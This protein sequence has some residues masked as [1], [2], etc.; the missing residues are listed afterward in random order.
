ML[1]LTAFEKDRGLP[2]HGAGGPQNQGATGPEDQRTTGPEPHQDGATPGLDKGTLERSKFYKLH[3]LL[4]VE[5]VQC[6]ELQIDWSWSAD[7]SI[8]EYGKCCK[9]PYLLALECFKCCISQ[10]LLVLERFNCGKLQHL[11]ISA[12]ERDRE[13]LDH[14]TGGPRD[15]RTTGPEDKNNKHTQETLKKYNSCQ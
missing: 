2:D 5:H 7:N 6:C 15:P 10:H 4:V 3:N 12:F 1:P 13:P 11:Q 8:L 9:L 14:G